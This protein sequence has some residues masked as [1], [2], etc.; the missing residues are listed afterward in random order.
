[1][2]FRTQ[3]AA[4][5]AGLFIVAGAARADLVSAVSATST[6]GA[7]FSTSLTNTINGVGLSSLALNATHEGTTP[8]N[9]WASDNG[10][11]AGLITFDLGQVHPIDG[12]SFWNQNGGG[13]GLMGITGI[14]RVI[15]LAST[16]GTNLAPIAG[17]PG[18]FA[19]QP[20]SMNVAAEVIT[21]NAVMARYI[22]FDVQSNWG[23]TQNTGFG[24]VHFSAV[25]APS[26]FTGL[27]AG[28]ALARRRRR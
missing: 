23:D 11:L 19:Q 15:V 22:R 26:A 18:E 8:A 13:P 5:C 1:M 27:L 17:A 4:L 25:P 14:R 2:K 3:E 24:E 6:M 7:D 12:F 20:G 21:F 10:V 9:S 16:D 28:L